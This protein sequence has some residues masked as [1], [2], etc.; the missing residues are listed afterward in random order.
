MVFHIS[1]PLLGLS[2]V[3]LMV[4]CVFA[5]LGI[6]YTYVIWDYQRPYRGTLRFKYSIK[7]D[8]N[9]KTEASGS[10]LFRVAEHRVESSSD[11]YDEAGVPGTPSTRDARLPH[12]GEERT[13]EPPRLPEVGEIPLVTRQAVC[14]ELWDLTGYRVVETEPKGH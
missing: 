1:L 12:G 4:M 9:E 3:V 6:Y 5:P 7:R 8:G 2:I 11:C 10:S 13:Q 14:V